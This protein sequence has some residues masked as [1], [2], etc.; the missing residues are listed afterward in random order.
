M[1][2]GVAAASLVTAVFIPEHLQTIPRQMIHGIH[3]GFFVLGGITVLSTIVFAELKKS[4]GENTSRQQVDQTPGDAIATL[5]PS[6]LR[7]AHRI[8]LDAS[9]AG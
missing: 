4:D 6:Q 5:S 3:D 7:P 9:P 2:F 1:S 8:G